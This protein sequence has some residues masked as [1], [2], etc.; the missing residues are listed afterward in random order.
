MKTRGIIAV[1]VLALVLA[2]GWFAWQRDVPQLVWQKVGPEPASLQPTNE[3]LSA[4]KVKRRAGAVVAVPEDPN[5]TLVMWFHG[6]GEQGDTIL[7][8][9]QHVG[10]RDRLLD[11]GYSLAGAD[12]GGDAWG[13]LASVKAYREAITWA[14]RTAGTDQLVLVG[15]SMG[16]LASLQ[17]A[18][19]LPDVAAWVGLSPVCNLASVAPGFTDAPEEPAERLS[20]VAG[21]YDGL[22]MLWFT[23]DND[24]VVPRDSNTDVCSAE[25]ADAGAEVEVVDVIG[26]H[27]NQSVF[28]P[29]TLLEFLTQTTAS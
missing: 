9:P 2:G 8:G 4:A 13:D 3:G 26:E 5:G 6:H 17:L 25:A 28:Q 21:D 18:D 12:A 15:Q 22:P 14:S 10:T 29:E 19:D 23:S 7:E 27:G 24:T 1:V 11:A 20:P 16:G